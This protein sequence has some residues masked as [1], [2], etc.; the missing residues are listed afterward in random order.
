VGDMLAGEQ[1]TKGFAM[2][3]NF[4]APVSVVAP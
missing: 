1:R 3:T 4:I 2:Q